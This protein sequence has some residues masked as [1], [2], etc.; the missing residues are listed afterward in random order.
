MSALLAYSAIGFGGIGA[1]CLCMLLLHRREEAQMRI[2]LRAAAGIER[3]RTDRAFLSE[4]LA[5][6]TL[7]Y[8]FSIEQRIDCGLISP[9]LSW[10]KRRHMRDSI[11][12][13]EHALQAGVLPS[14]GYQGFRETQIRM[15]LGVGVMLLLIGLVFSTMLGVILGLIGALMGYQLPR[16]ALLQEESARAHALEQ[17]LPELLDVLVLGLRSGL[18]FDRSFMLYWT[19]FQ[20][21]F[22]KECASVQRAWSLGFSTRQEALQRFADS[23]CSPSFQRV[24]KSIQRS[25]RL[26]S[27]LADNLESSAS[28]IRAICKA[29][30]QETTAKA[31][32][33]M[34][35]PIATLILP[36]MLL[37]VLGPTLLEL[38]EGF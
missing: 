31:P 37:L 5:A 33:K 20:T 36:A 14:V 16:W 30:Q 6:R 13:D 11:W 26:G 7:G 9:V 35:V 17:E 8:L 34:M 3:Q 1:S 21:P 23:Y 18:T 15:S 10:D 27:S 22:A 19:H 24:V 25:L 32:V 4:G 2:A 29:K 38:A 28:E 12:F